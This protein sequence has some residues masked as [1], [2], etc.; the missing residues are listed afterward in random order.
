MS[1]P[2]IAAPH[3]PN[4]RPAARCV[5]AVLALVLALAA[6][7]H[8]ASPE[9]ASGARGM[10]VTPHEAVTRAG[11]RVLERG[12]NAIDAAIAAGFALAVAQPQSTG[13][14]GGAF[15]IVRLADGRAF[16]IDARETAPAAAHPGLY[17]QPGLAPDASRFGGLAVGTPG[18]VAGFALAL[19]QYGTFSLKQALA[20]AIA[21]ASEGAEIGPHW[22]RMIEFMR[23][24]P[25]PARFP[26]TARIQLPPAPIAPGAK[27]RQPEL[28]ETLRLIARRGPRAFYEGPLAA[29]IA[30]AARASGGVLTEADLA[31]YRPLVRE[32]L[33]GGYRGLELL[34]FPLPSSGGVTLL[35]MLNVLAGYDLGA[36]GA[37]SSLS[38]HRIAETMKLAF[39]DRAQQLGDP[40]IV[41][42]P[43]K[44]LLDPAYAEALRARIRDER[45]TPVDSSQ[46]AVDDDGTAH[47]SVVDAAGNAVAIT[48]T[49]N[50]PYGAWVTVPGTGIVLNNEMDDFVTQ[51]GQANQ[52]GLA[53][54]ES[55]A[56]RVEAGK[57]PL[58]S[59][60]PL[61]VVGDGKLRFVAGGNGG[62]RILSSVLL[63]FLAVVDW[64]KDAQEAV[65]V[66]RFH[67]QWRPDVLEVE[68][69]TPADVVAAL[70]ARGHE[71]K[72][73]DEITSGVE[74]IVIDPQTG[75]MTGGADPRRDSFA[76]GLD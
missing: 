66:P 14:G 4:L 40:A 32:P 29:K 16:A 52:W 49:V 10:V 55:A 50:G 21:L 6:G 62:P 5:A 70:R 57:R 17:S 12:G 59:M 1:T 67:H 46:L 39:A 3:F 43:I 54:L 45:V 31:A 64:G 25:L 15:L 71:V 19:E 65:S 30:A 42:S 35:Q 27:L 33:R 63:T 61:I 73:S 8:G 69:E 56:N 22:R 9:P 68:A 23:A 20:P 74:A 26:E 13:I 34:A 48:E 60:A 76:L 58:S 75:R 24:T 38:I 18:L 7:A 28:A 2:Q 72:V 44:R 36:S 53:G 11:V 47:L 37:G 51:P 41:D